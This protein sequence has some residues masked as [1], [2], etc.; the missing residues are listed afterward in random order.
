MRKADAVDIVA[1]HV[2]ETT[3]TRALSHELVTHA[4]YPL[5]PEPDWCDVL[6]LAD[7]K[8]RGTRVYTIQQAYQAL[9]QPERHGP[10]AS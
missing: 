6:D 10:G 1:R 8:A 3:W 7:L 5:I 9:Q 4:D 2:L